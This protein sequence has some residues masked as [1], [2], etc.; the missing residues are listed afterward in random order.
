MNEILA[1]KLTI[2]RV[3]ISP[4]SF[5][6]GFGHVMNIEQSNAACTVLATTLLDIRRGSGQNAITLSDGRNSTRAWH[7]ND[8]FQGIKIL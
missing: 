2:E 7:A 1:Q 4:V 5:P 3:I 6:V 8:H